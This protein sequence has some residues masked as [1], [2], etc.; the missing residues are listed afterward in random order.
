[1][2]KLFA[3]LTALFPLIYA[4]SMLI[5]AVL[6]TED[7][8]LFTVLGILLLV[9]ILLPVAFAATSGKAQRKF[10]ALCNLWFYACNLLIFAGE[11]ILWVVRFRENQI[12]SQNGAWEGG[13]VLVLLFLLYLPHWT[14]YLVVRI[15]G[16]ISTARTL[17]G[18]SEDSTRMSHTF[19]QLI[20]VVDL[21]SAI[22]VLRKVNRFL[23]C[24]Q[25][26]IETK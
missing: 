8:A 25:P 20:P 2:K 5:L 4:I 11:L 3:V 24:Q 21:V 15:V 13:L 12:A 16:A 17:K 14:V 7:E 19:L 9:G 26:P 22:L 23:S 18:V 6:G 10:L 1:M